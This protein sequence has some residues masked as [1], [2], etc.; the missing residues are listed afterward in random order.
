MI[1]KYNI[2]NLIPQLSID[3]VVFGYEKADLK[4][5]LPKLNLSGDH[6][7]LPGGFINQ[8][9]S[10]DEAALRILEIRTGINKIYLEQFRVY[11]EIKRNTDNFNKNLLSKNQEELDKHNWDAKFLHWL[12]K[13]FISIGYYALVDIRN[14]EPKKSLVDQSIDWYDIKNLPTLIFDHEQ[15][16]KDALETLRFQ[17]D[18]KLIGFNLLPETFTMK[19][20]QKLYEAVYD[21][22]FR[23]NN[24]Q[25]KML[26]LDIL[27]RLGKQYTGAKNK[28]PY[29]YR[30]KSPDSLEL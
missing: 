30:F 19:Q 23:N 21:R 17:L 16:V 27:E 12:N 25:K 28:A 10:I 4:V 6:W 5:L 24:F 18:R 2:D 20:L 15:M 14:V 9:E 29:L 26:S 11:G 1:E 7:A 3:C 22:P 13:R 8:E